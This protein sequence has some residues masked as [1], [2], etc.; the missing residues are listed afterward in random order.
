MKRSTDEPWGWIFVFSLIPLALLALV[1]F[2]I[3]GEKLC[4]TELG[5]SRCIRYEEG[6]SDGQTAVVVLMIIYVFVPISAFVLWIKDRL[7]HP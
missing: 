5:S 4:V 7:E 2:A 1:Y 6:Q 3:P